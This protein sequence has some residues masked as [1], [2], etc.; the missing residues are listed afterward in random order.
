MDVITGNTDNIMVVQ[1]L[2]VA[3]FSPTGTSRKVAESIANGVHC[4]NVSTLDLT[5]APA[6]VTV[7]SD[8]LTIVAMPV[9]GGHLPPLAVERMR[10]LRADGAPA[11]AVVV[12]GNRAYEHALEELAELLA[13][14]DF[15]VIAA[16][17]FIGE[18]SYSTAQLP[19]AQGRP[20]AKDLSFAEQFGEKVAAKL[21]RL[22]ALAPASQVDVKKIRKPRQHPFAMMRFTIGA[23][24]MIMGKVRMPLTPSVDET[25][26]LHCGKCANLCPTG[27]IRAGEEQVTDKT[28][29][30]KCCACVKGCPV[31]ARTFPTP[32]AKLLAANFKH[33]KS[34]KQLL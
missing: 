7:A 28:R 27:A 11:V 2:T 26:C 24:R 21:S 20:D 17:T 13:G 19:I 29:C 25:L 23:M 3:Y 10:D 32:F 1:G 4:A 33:R 18:H 30:I 12:Y 22:T 16:A 9:Y 6:S 8:N 14:N 34:P 15:K 31:G 5:H